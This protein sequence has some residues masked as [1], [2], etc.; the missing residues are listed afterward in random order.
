M[1]TSSAQD[2]MFVG[3]IGGCALDAALF[4]VEKSGGG[5]GTWLVPWTSSSCD[6]LCSPVGTEGELVSL[7]MYR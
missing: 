1:G 6:E 5:C 4:A 3:W 2:G 7:S